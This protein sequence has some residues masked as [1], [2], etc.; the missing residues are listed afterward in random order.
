MNGLQDLTPYFTECFYNRDGKW[1]YAG[2]YKAVK[3]EDLT[4]AEYSNLSPEVYSL[5]HF[6]SITQ[7]LQTTQ[8]LIR[9]TISGRRGASPQNFY[10]TGQL[11]SIGALK[12]SCVGLQCVAFNNVL[13]RAVLEHAA[14]FVQSAHGNALGSGSGWNIQATVSSLKAIGMNKDSIP[15]VVDRGSRRDRKENL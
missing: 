11:Y 7:G 8:A 9:E 5:S 14:K 12:V 3:L 15:V 6:Y 4:A 2:T 1:Y 10:E 13:Y